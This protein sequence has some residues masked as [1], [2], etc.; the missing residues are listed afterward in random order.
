MSILSDRLLFG[1]ARERYSCVGAPTWITGERQ[2]LDTT[3]KIQLSRVLCI[4][5]KQLNS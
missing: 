3:G 4:Y 1:E 2:L 5:F